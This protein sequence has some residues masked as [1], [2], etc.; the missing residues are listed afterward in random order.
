[1]KTIKDIYEIEKAL[2]IHLHLTRIALESHQLD[3][4]NVFRCLE[5]SAMKRYMANR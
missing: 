2:Y 5:S 1:M 4:P 3:S